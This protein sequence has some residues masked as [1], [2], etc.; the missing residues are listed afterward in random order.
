MS[1]SQIL[2]TGIISTSGILNSNLMPNSY[3]MPYGTSNYATGTWRGAGTNTMQQKG[4]VYIENGMYGFKQIGIQTAND[5]SCWCIDSFPTEANTDYI[6][7]MYAKM[8]EGTGGQAGFYI[9]RCTDVAGSHTKID[10]NYRVT[11]LTKE[12]TRCWY[13]FKTNSNTTRN[14]YIGIT[15]EDVSVT[16][17][18]CLIKLEKGTRLTPWIPYETD[19]I[20]VGNGPGFIETLY[21][22]NASVSKEYIEANQ[23]YEI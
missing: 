14:F 17:F 19:E 15:T 3:I 22:P 5:A 8:T 13:Q 2:K 20:Y 7:S 4:R 18:M 1:N 11:P 9:Q 16:T 10:K 23:F 21:T 12:W 6:I